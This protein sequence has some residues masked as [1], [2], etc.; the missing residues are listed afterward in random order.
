MKKNKEKVIYCWNCG[1]K[2]KKNN[3]E[4]TKC[5]QLLKE[6]ERPILHWFFGEAVDEVKGNIF[7][8]ASQALINFFHL[9]LYGMTVGLAVAFAIAASVFN[10]NTNSTLEVTTEEYRLPSIEEVPASPEEPALPEE[11]IEEQ[12]EVEQLSCESGYT[13]SG[14]KCKMTEY[15]DAASREACPEGYTVNFYYNDCQSNEAV[16]V[17][18]EY[19]CA[20]TLEEYHRYPN[21]TLPDNTASIESVGPKKTTG[22]SLWCDYSFKDLNGNDLGIYSSTMALEKRSCPPG[23]EG[24]YVCRRRTALITEYSCDAGYTLTADHRC[25]KT[26]EKD[27]IRR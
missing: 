16:D 9:H 22:E 5:E 24:E 20:K 13:L 17:T 2:N 25:S 4:C 23:M 6:K 8:K 18:I 21:P 14:N 19:Y 27:P 10:F 3:R 11:V 15:K 26:I 1:T 7:S 12:P